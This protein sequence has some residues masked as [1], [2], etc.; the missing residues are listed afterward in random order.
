MNVGYCHPYS[1]LAVVS[2]AAFPHTL[3]AG[4]GRGLVR[5]MT[6]GAQMGHW[7]QTPSRGGACKGRR[8]Q[9]E[10]GWEGREQDLAREGQGVSLV[11]LECEER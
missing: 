4:K 2:P 10:G 9:G 6:R 1:C 11:W 7:G 5:A 3:S 8:E